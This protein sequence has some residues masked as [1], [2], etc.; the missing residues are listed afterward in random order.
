MKRLIRIFLLLALAVS[1]SSCFTMMA[2]A[3]SGKKTLKKG[4]ELG[5][6]S[7]RMELK[8]IQRIADNA[9]LA[10]TGN[11]DL[12]CVFAVFEEYYDGL[13]LSGRFTKQGSYTFK[14]SR[15]ASRTVLVYT[16]DR[17]KKKLKSYVENFLKENSQSDRTE[18]T[19]IAI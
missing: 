3:S 17:D 6:D 8:M 18:S 11:G 4:D 12:V 14:D 13:V 2:I 15:G 1:A 19:T 5:K 10:T 7:A 16:Y 9:A